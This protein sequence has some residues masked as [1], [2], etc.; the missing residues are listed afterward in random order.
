[1]SYVSFQLNSE[2]VAAIAKVFPIFFYFVAALVSLTTMTRMIE[3]ERTLI[4]LLK[5]LG[6]KRI[7]IV[8]KYVIYCGL[9]S[10]LGSLA[11]LLV[12]FKLIPKVLW[13]AYGVMYHLPPFITEFNTKI[14]LIASGA[15]VISTVGVTIYVA[16]ETLRE[17]PATLMLPKAPKAGK[18]ILL[19]KI[20]PLWRRMSFNVKSTAR[21]IFRYKKHFYMTVV[22][23]SGCTALLVTGFGLKD[24]IGHFAGTQFDE[25]FKYQVNVELDEKELLGK[26]LDSVFED[27][28][29]IGE[30]TGIYTD[31]GIVRYKGDNLEG[32]GMAFQNPEDLT[33]FIEV[34]NRETQELIDSGEEYVIITEKLSEVL[35]ISIGET[36]VFEDSDNNRGEFVVT[37]ITENY[38]LNYIYMDLGTYQSVFGKRE[39][40]GALVRTEGM[41][42]EGED[43]LVKELLLK[44][45]VK[46]AESLK[47]TCS[48]FTPCPGG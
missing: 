3:E 13:N 6:F 26:N 48:T 42:S 32:I 44:D 1:M 33:E 43:K 9:A 17:K 35:G 25:I 41:D 5:A 28:E 46:N 4:G 21:N 18:R 23:I 27:V 22:G 12:G 37:D 36:I 14:A 47:R 2:K 30:Y 10:I 38:I 19:E 34:R 39:I 11:G 20:G 8:G 45:P 15:A 7:A 29:G 16:N 31:K 24:S 40:N